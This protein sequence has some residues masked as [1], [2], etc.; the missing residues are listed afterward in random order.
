MLAANFVVN[1]GGHLRINFVEGAR[2]WI[3]FH[4]VCE[5]LASGFWCSFSLAH[6]DFRV[7]QFHVLFGSLKRCESKFGV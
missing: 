5:H 2:H 1:G 3:I 7:M 4:D 6:V